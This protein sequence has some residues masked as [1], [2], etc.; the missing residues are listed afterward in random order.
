MQRARAD[1]DIRQSEAHRDEFI[2]EPKHVA[3]K[4]RHTGLCFQCFLTQ[5]DQMSIMDIVEDVI[6]YDF[7]KGDYGY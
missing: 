4:V 2:P 5:I 6:V 3:Y 1:V 7:V